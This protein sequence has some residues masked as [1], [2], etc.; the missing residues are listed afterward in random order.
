M[1]IGA[2]TSL[3]ALLP[4][5]SAMSL[6]EPC[7]AGAGGADVRAPL[8]MMMGANSPTG[9]GSR[10]GLFDSLFSEEGPPQIRSSRFHDLAQRLAP[11]RNG[12]RVKVLFAEGPGEPVPSVRFITTFFGVETDQVYRWVSSDIATWA[13]WVPMLAALDV[14]HLEHTEITGRRGARQRLVMTMDGIAAKIVGLGTVEVTHLLEE[15][16]HEEIVQTRWSRD[17]STEGDLAAHRGS[18]TFLPS[19]GAEQG[20]IA[21]YEGLQVPRFVMN[22]NWLL[23]KATVAAIRRQARDHLRTMVE[24]LAHRATDPTWN[25]RSAHRPHPVQFVLEDV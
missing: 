1:N 12:D 5:I 25:K 8:A 17:D 16:T 20:T 6:L 10:R 2:L 15:E 3:E 18:W 13:D 24:Y 21:V 11:A 19:Q 7:L 22:Q 23:R 9:G 4:M 14:F